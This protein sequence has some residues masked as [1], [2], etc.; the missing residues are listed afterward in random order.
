MLQLRDHGRLMRRSYAEVQL[1]FEGK[2]YE[3][4]LL[5]KHPM[6]RGG[7]GRLVVTCNMFQ[8]N[9][10][11]LAEGSEARQIP[12]R[13]PLGVQAGK[14]IIA[15]FFS[16]SYY[17]RQLLLLLKRGCVPLCGFSKACLK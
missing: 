1:V 13:E 10:R 8:L 3:K 11:G 17:C 16:G 15:I 14:Q 5:I 6:L 12:V 9:R 4:C 2:K 7:C